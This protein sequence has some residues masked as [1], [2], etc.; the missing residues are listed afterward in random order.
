MAIT[1]SSRVKKIIKAML[2]APDFIT[3]QQIADQIDV[4]RRTVLR[5]MEDAY[6]WLEDKQVPFTKIKNK[7]LKVEIPEGIRLTLLDELHN[8]L[9][10]YLYTKEERQVY[11][12][13]ELLQTTEPSKLFAFATT[14][15][16]SEATVSHDLDAVETWLLKYHIT[17]VRK[18][19]IG[20]Y[21]E[22][23]ERDIRRALVTILY[24][25]LDLD[26]VRNVLSDYVN[27]LPGKP[28][29][30][31]A[32][33]SRL[34]HLIDGD[35]VVLIQ[36]AIDQSEQQMGFTFAEASYTAL[37]VHLALAIKRIQKGERIV[38]APDVLDGF[39]VYEEFAIA[40]NLIQ[41]LRDVLHLD[42]PDD[43]IGYVTMHL[44]GA[45][46]KSGITESSV[47]RWN[48]VVISNYKLTS[49]IH[50]M[51][52]AAE[53]KT[54]YPL[55]K[56]E[57]LLIGLVEHMRP[58]INRLQMNLEIRNP[59]LNFIQEKYPDIYEVSKDAAKVIE[60]ELG[61]HLPDAEIG[62]LAMH[63]G[64]AIERI[65]NN[66]RT[67]GITYNIVVTC[68]SGI[69]TSRMLAERIRR[70]FDNIRIVDVF[71]TTAL[72]DD[73]LREHHIDLIVSTV[74]FESERLPMVVVNPL[75]FP[76]DIDT[77]NQT[78]SRITQSP[79]Q[80]GVSKNETPI[81]LTT[82]L[83]RLNQYTAAILEILTSFVV[84]T[85]LDASTF[86]DFVD[87][88]AHRIHSS[89]K[90][91]KRLKDDI[92][93]RERMGSLVF[94]DER[95]VLLHTR[96][97]T[98]SS[99]HVAVYRNAQPVEYEGQTVNAALVMLA[100][101]DI[102]TERLDVIGAISAR[103]IQ[104]PTFLMRIRQANEHIVKEHIE[105]IVTAFY[106]EQSKSI[107]GKDA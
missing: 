23:K 62:F 86:R 38:I 82:T 37:A 73:W 56:Q 106:Q 66:E 81:D 83:R 89:N 39:R 105:S 9:E 85:D 25:N 72:Q 88:I 6:G 107:Q 92:W 65:R 101:K 91:A 97:E 80:G 69:G 24:E 78:L 68:T 2:Q 98:M 93:K 7:G 67:K 60:A 34:L 12:T 19:G 29:Q 51:I 8:E 63:I 30:M 33:K 10:D 13:T 70:E 47:L 95:V 103:L 100:P 21:I 26:Q 49:I 40:R 54:G 11:I 46:Y 75:L 18:Q 5:D 44:K 43:E 104:D 55:L 41:S 42:I 84:D 50:K 16:V 77:L 36:Q 74:H 17:L 71:S 22:G 99:L 58:A 79:R 61:V 64:S 3:V 94:A 15:H 96:S 76:G 45:R 31:S 4:S 1:L 48:E 53:V 87:A 35:T 57:T 27:V 28:K 14:L 20:V 102:E 59:L 32:I 90:A 52:K